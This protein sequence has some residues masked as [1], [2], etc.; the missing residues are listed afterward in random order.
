MSSAIAQDYQGNTAPEA[1]NE[2]CM[3]HQHIR[4]ELHS[5]SLY[6]T[7]DISFSSAELTTLPILQGKRAT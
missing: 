3:N 5:G 1:E 6:Y 7:S 2:E 4:K